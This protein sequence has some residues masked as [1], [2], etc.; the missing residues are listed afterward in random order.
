MTKSNELL[1]ILQTPVTLP[2]GDK[3]FPSD[4]GPPNIYDRIAALQIE[5]KELRVAGKPMSAR[6]KLNE[7]AHFRRLIKRI[8]KR[9]KVLGLKTTDKGK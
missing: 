3:P 7:A 8:E 5:S 6:K 1:E 9:W 4:N 2:N